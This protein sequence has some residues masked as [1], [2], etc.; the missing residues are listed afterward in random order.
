MYVIDSTMF[1]KFYRSF[2]L[3]NIAKELPA[4][5]IMSYFLCDFWYVS[6][7]TINTLAAK[8]FHTIGALKTNRILYPFGI[9]KKLSE[10]AVLLSVT[11]SDFNLM[12]V[13]K[14]NYYVYRYE[15]KPNGIENAVILLNYPEKAFGNPKA[16]RAFLCTDISLSTNELLFCY[17]CR[18]FIEVFFG[19]C[20]D[21]LALNRYHIRSA[22]GLRRY[23]LSMSLAHYICVMGTGE[24][25][26][27]AK[28]YHLICD[29]IRQEMYRY[30]F[31][32]VKKSNDFDSF[33]KLKVSFCAPLQICSFIVCQNIFAATHHILE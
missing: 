27:F 18:W 5:P 21:K 20:K 3:W 26:S 6:E 17:V 24:A 2:L 16:L 32:C 33:M 23:W 15:V 13:K 31:Q 11:R 30:L 7:I 19:Q 1:Y 14:Q 4:P 28:G 9:K 29:I 8:G 25:C 10:F 22:Q 12:T